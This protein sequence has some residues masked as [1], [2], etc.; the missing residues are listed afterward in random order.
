MRVEHSMNRGAGVQQVRR[1]IDRLV[2]DGAVVARSDRT[3]HRIF[4][5]AV[6]AEEGEALRNWVLREGATQTIEIGLGYGISALYI[7]EGLL[8]NG[9]AA[10]RHIVIDPFQT[11]RFADC[12]LQALEE[13]G[14]TQ[15]VEHYAEKSHIAL[16]RFLSE[17]RC[18]DLGFIDGNHRFDGV[19]LDIYYLGLLVRRGG[20]IILDDYG[21]PAIKRAVSFF[22]TNLNWTIEET[23]HHL[24]VLRTAKDA[25]NRDFT[26]FVEF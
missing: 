14:L 25:D 12:G 11:T 17:D 5:V 16:P 10:A 19:F 23:S 2:R 18:F 21:L 4:P 22:V 6:G 13:A 7:C 3:T 26:D 24:A 15:L 1:V 20:I 9:T 8:A